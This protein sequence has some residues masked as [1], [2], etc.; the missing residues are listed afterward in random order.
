MVFSFVLTF[1]AANEPHGSLSNR[2]LL[3]THGIPR[4]SRPNIRRFR[5]DRRI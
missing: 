3:G 1:G 5:C 2:R 4:R